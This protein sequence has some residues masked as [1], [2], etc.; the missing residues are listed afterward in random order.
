LAERAGGGEADTKKGGQREVKK[1]IS[2]KKVTIT[3]R[4]SEKGKYFGS[5]G[6]E[7]DHKEKLVRVR[8]EVAELKMEG[9]RRRQQEKGVEKKRASQ[10][11]LTA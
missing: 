1:R 4:P 9:G 8:G 2:S 6:E 3:P 10:T 5:R 11:K 7:G